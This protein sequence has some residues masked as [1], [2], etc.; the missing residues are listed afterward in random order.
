MALTCQHGVMSLDGF[1]VCGQELEHLSCAQG[2][3]P[4]PQRPTGQWHAAATYHMTKSCCTASRYGTVCDYER[5]LL[6]ARPRGQAGECEEETSCT[7]PEWKRTT[8]CGGSAGHESDEELEARPTRLAVILQRS[9]SKLPLDDAVFECE[10]EHVQWSWCLVWRV[11][12]PK[13]RCAGIKLHKVTQ[14][15]QLLKCCTT[16]SIVHFSC[17]N[18][19]TADIRRCVCGTY[20]AY[21]RYATR[22]QDT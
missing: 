13:I 14:Y 7:R 15:Q 4:T 1:A 6:G 8:R 12:P 11:S 2:K 19:S 9:A 10:D 16:E 21:V 17:I 20:R 3:P 5:A 22:C 18:L